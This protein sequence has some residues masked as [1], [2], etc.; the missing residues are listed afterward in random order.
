MVGGSGR[1]EDELTASTRGARRRHGLR[2][3]RVNPPLNCGGS[4]DLGFLVLTASV[5]TAL[6]LLGAA[7]RAA[8]STAL[9]RWG[10]AGA[11]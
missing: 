4:F 2:T 1:A 11:Q 6:A 8:G 5:A 7:T 9:R 10:P 3:M